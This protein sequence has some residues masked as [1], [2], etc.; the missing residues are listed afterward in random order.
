MVRSV[1]SSG[2]LRR[3]ANP[4]K[5]CRPMNKLAGLPQHVQIQFA[6]QVPRAADLKRIEHRPVPDAVA[7]NLP[8]RGK[9]RVE[10]VGDEPHASHADLGGQ[11]GVERAA[12]TFGGMLQFGGHVG[13]ERPAR[14]RGPR[15]PCGRS[16]ARPRAASG[17]AWTGRFPAGFGS[18]CRAPGFCQ[19]R[20]GH[21]S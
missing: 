4:A 11:P 14:G 12:P 2:W 5:S 17:K 19:P 20:N 6:G 21:P 3:A 16:R 1:C 9:A 7:V 10:R 18:C 13:V 8:P 15:R